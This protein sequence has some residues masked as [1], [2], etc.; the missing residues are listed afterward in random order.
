MSFTN[1]NGTEIVISTP[2]RTAIGTFGGAIKDVP[3]VDLGTTVAKAII[4]R[5]GIDAE[6]INQVIV[7]NI[8]MAGQ[9]MNPGR[10]VGIN[11][12]IPETSP[13]MTLNRMCASGLQAIVSAAQEIALGESDV[14]LAGGI[15]NM[16]M[17]PFLLPK[18]RYG[19]R[20]GLPEAKMGLLDHMVYD[21]LWD[22]FN[23][24]HMGVTAE[25]VAEQYG[26]SRDEVDEYSARSHQR[27]EKSRDEGYFDDQIVPVEIKQKK[28]TVEFTKDEHIREGATKEGLSKLKPFFK[29]DGVTTAAS[30]SGV[31]DG[32]SMTLV[33]SA[34]KAEE[35]GLPVAGR[36]VS[37]AVAG[38]DPS[39]M[40]IGM[41]PASHQALKKAGLSIDDMDVVEANEA[42]ASV[43]LAVQRD[44]GI[45]DEVINPVGGAISLGHPIGATGAVL[46]TKILHELDRIQGRYGL[47]T[48]CVG[49]GMGIAAIYE[50]V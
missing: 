8:L 39:V 12:G 23:D 24:Y 50:R 11:S 7:G 10:Q 26:L 15:E 6:E 33:A 20:M 21:G 27:A 40:G 2:L 5:S 46:T 1:G 25:N 43:T 49:G 35:L 18:G 17:A 16:D 44:L 38:V 31:N 36:L 41:V 32:A 30:A 14:I 37:A 4:S 22:K 28:E 19:Y 34:S 42:F 48:L 29:E 13:A 9:G 45:S 3:A 47:V